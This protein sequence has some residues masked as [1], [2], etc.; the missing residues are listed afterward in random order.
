MELQHAKLIAAMVAYDRW[1][2][3]RIQHFMKVH[4]FAATIGILEGL[5]VETLFILETAAIVHDIGIHIS[6]LK[7]GLCD[8][9]HQELEGPAEAE[10]LLSTVGGYSAEQIDRVCWLVGHH[11]TYR[12]VEGMDYQI[13]L[14]A[15]FLVNLYED[16]LQKEA[17]ESAKKKIFKTKTGIQLLEDIFDCRQMI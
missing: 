13:L 8:G 16:K 1:D 14:E 2:T 5:D 17:I 15:D 4:N 12:N 11:H 7:Y 10:K 3:P 6:E 9:K